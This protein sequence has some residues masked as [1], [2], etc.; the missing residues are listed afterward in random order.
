MECSGK[1]YSVNP[2]PDQIFGIKTYLN[3]KQNKG[4]V[5]LIASIAPVGISLALAKSILHIAI[6]SRAI[7]NAYMPITIKVAPPQIVGKMP[8]N[9]YV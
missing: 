7:F 8:V 5:G 1:I 9:R 4:D 2:N 6:G 3:L